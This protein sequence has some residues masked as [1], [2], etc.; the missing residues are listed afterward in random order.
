MAESRAMGRVIKRGAGDLGDISPETGFADTSPGA[1]GGKVI[2]GEAFSAKGDAQGIRDRAH[3]E[4][5]Q[6]VAQ[7]RAEAERIKREAFEQA[8]RKGYDDGRQ[9]GA[10]ELAEIVASAAQRLKQI[11]AQ[12]IPQLKDLA[13]AIAR[14]I[15]GKELEFHPEAV[16]DIIKQ[17]L[18][19]KARQRREIFLRVNPADLQVLRER[20]EEL[21]EV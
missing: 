15:L 12:A 2:S 13:L 21:V 7:A 18:S 6:I 3:E 19:E 20:K 5:D 8:K 10:E 14:K 1:R 16:V 9:K 11:E 4:A 17:A